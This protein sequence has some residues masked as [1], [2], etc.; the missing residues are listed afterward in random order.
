M[1]SRNGITAQRDGSYHCSRTFLSLFALSL[2]PP[3]M[4]DQKPRFFFGGS[5]EAD[6]GGGGAL[7]SSDTATGGRLGSI[8]TGAG[9][10]VDANTVAAANV[11]TGI[12]WR[13]QYDV[14][15]V[16][17]AKYSV[18]TIDRAETSP[19]SSRTTAWLQPS[20]AS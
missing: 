11:N 5:S 6:G 19:L 1:T 15:S 14:G 13:S 17:R 9:F 12:G 18:Y 10:S 16:P 4:R 8:W 2:P 20:A 3:K 7:L